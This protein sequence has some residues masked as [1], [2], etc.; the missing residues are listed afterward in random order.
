MTRK[1]FELIAR[2]L[3]DSKPDDL[4]LRYVES[5]AIAWNGIVQ[6]FAN[7]LQ[8]TNLRFDVDKFRD[9]CSQKPD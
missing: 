5:H 2:V 7:E 4:L 1:D 3:R 9:A 8:K 6:R